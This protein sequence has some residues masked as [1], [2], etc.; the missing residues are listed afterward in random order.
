MGDDMTITRLKARALMLL[1][2]IILPACGSTHA[3]NDSNAAVA[4]VTITNTPNATAPADSGNAATPAATNS[5]G[6]GTDFMVGKWSA[7][8][9]DCSVVIDFHKDGSVTTPIGVAKW[10]AIGDK[11][12]IA[13][14]DG[15]APTVSSIKVL[16]PAR[17]EITHSSGTKETEKR[18]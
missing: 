11:L 18:C 14:P 6:F 15:S 1:G 4:E 13:Y 17:I 16:D 5:R 10:T 12:S 3:A 9:E 7:M 8:G 2:I